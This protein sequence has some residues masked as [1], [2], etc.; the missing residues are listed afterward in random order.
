MQTIAQ[1]ADKAFSA[2]AARIGGAVHPMV[3]KRKSANEYNPATGGWTTLLQNADGRIVFDNATPPADV[4]PDYVPGPG[5][6]LAY[7]EGLP[8][9][10]PREGDSIEAVG[11]TFSVIRSANLLYAAG[12]WPVVLR[13]DGVPILTSSFSGEFSGDFG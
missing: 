7:C 10:M 6:E 8:S 9:L 4:F 3:I 5:E 12:L 11:K 13:A 2:V 1:I